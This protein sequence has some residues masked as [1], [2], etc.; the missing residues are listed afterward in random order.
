VQTK[1]LKKLRASRNNE[2]VQQR[3]LAIREAA[4]TDRNIM[5]F[6]VEAVSDYCTLGEIADALR[7][8]FG[9]YK[10]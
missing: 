8:V 3:L 7:S 1:K 9:E 4:A 10:G 2:V 5:P 6:V